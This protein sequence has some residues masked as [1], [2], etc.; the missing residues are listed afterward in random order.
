[1]L[2]VFVAKLG[3]LESKYSTLKI[4]GI[5]FTAVVFSFTLSL[6]YMH[7]YYEPY[8]SCIKLEMLPCSSISN[9]LVEWYGEWSLV[10][11]SVLSSVLVFVFFFR[12]S[13]DKSRV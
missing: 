5:S 4:L 10:F 12:K 2:L 11:N 9:Y 13:V 6:G 8:V 7:F 3:V 1:V